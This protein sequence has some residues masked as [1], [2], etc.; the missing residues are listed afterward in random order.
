MKKL[1]TLLTLVMFAFMANAQL[2]PLISTTNN[3]ALDTVTN[4]ASKSL[5]VA[6]SGPQSIVTI[7]ATVTKISG[8]VAGTVRLLGSIDGVNYTA[9]DAT[10]YTATDV[11]GGQSTSWIVTPSKYVNYK[12]TYT[13]TGTMVASLAAKSMARK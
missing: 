6:V 1:F 11:A 8:T 5:V 4:T 7:V 3:K 10:T 9:A 2:A 13:G 12:V